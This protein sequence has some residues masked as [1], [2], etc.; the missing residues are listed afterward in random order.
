MMRDLD[1]T[2]ARGTGAWRP[3]IGSTRHRYASAI[4]LTHVRTTVNGA[5]NQQHSVTI[6]FHRTTS[7]N[8]NPIATGQPET[9]ERTRMREFSRRVHGYIANARLQ[10]TLGWLG[11]PWRLT[12]N[13]L[14]IVDPNVPNT[15][16]FA[17]DATH[18]HHIHI[19]M[20]TD[21]P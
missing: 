8:S 18:V 3:H 19:S 10:G 4:D 15:E 16:A 5:N 2:Y 17:T 12:Y 13:Q 6:Q 14:D 9:A 7:P 1:I 11:G 21:Q 20:G